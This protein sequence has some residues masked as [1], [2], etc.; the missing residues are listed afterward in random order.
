MNAPINHAWGV[1]PGGD[2]IVAFLAGL[3]PSL[4][5]RTGLMTLQ[6]YLDESEDGDFFVLA[7]YISS[8]EKWVKFA[9]DWEDVLHFATQGKDGNYRFKMNEMAQNEERMNRVP[10]FYRIIEEFAEISVSVS[11]N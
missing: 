6:A 2:D 9:Q 10:Y 3:A 11:F 8:P 5:G 7:G 1:S 4:W